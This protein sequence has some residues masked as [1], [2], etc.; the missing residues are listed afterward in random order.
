MN[1]LNE[2]IKFVTD[3]RISDGAGGVIPT[4]QTILETFAKIEQLKRSRDLEQAQL[5]LPA[6]FRVM[7]YDR[8]D[9]SINPDMGVERRNK[10]Y[11]IISTPEM[12]DVRAMRTLTFDMTA[13]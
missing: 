11:N 6:V 3:G 7:I 1:K 4:T 2:K 10:I 12:D 8:K 13:R 9:F 5:Q